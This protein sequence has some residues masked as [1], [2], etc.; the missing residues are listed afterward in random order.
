MLV[1]ERP[2]TSA[3]AV[4]KNQS[5]SARI[6]KPR[7]AR[8]TNGCCGLQISG[9]GAR[10]TRRL[11]DRLHN[12]D[13]LPDGGSRPTSQQGK[14]KSE[15]NRFHPAETNPRRLDRSGDARNLSSAFDLIAKT[16][17]IPSPRARPARLDVAGFPRL[18]PTLSGDGHEHQAAEPNR[19]PKMNWDRLEG[20]WKQM[21]GKVQ[22]Q[23]GKLTND[24]MDLVEGK[25][26]E[27][28]GR[29]QERYGIQRDEAERQIDSW[30]RNL[31]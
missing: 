30:L 28:I 23:W 13:P 14:R 22:Q 26:T 17:R 7:T 15:S 25:R 24:D 16:G 2:S 11:A 21:K 18:R 20:N 8:R 12:T 10:V 1:S 9:R 3:A 4:P 5:K 29:L 6:S 31:T 27:L 19:R